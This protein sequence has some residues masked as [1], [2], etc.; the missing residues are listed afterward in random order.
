MMRRIAGE[1]GAA[2]VSIAAMVSIF[3][4]LN[5]SILSGARVPYAMARD[6]L[7]FR[8]VAKVHPEYRTPG[9][10][11][12]ALSAWAAVL[13]LSGRYEQL[14]HLCDFRELDLYG[15]TAASVLVLR[16][17]RPDLVRPYRTAGYPVVPVLFVLGAAGCD[18]VHFAAI[19][20]GIAARVGHH[21]S[22]ITLLFS[23]EAPEYVIGCRCSPP[24]WYSLQGFS[25]LVLNSEQNS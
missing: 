22:R 11:I 3:A 13:V 4:A 17:K 2:A 24:A 9:A 6:G 19:A 20:A 1:G 10:S 12:L 14:V 5:G 16:K 21:F 25:V 7:F 18:F 15:M 8:S 23:L